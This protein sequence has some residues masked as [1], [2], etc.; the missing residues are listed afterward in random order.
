MNLLVSLNLLLIAATHL[1]RAAELP[2][3]S[4][5]ACPKMCSCWDNLTVINCDKRGILTIP[6]H[7]PSV[8]RVLNLQ[9]NQISTIPPDVFSNLTSLVQLHLEKNLIAALQNDSLRGLKSL[10]FLFLRQRV[11]LIAG[12]VMVYFVH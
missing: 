6:E 3:P 11:Y 2:M 12:L 1:L 10:Q 4:S 9:E 8:A 5:D 7:I